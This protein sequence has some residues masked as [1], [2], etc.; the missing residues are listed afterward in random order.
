LIGIPYF[1]NNQNNLPKSLLEIRTS[2]IQGRG[3]FATRRIRKGTRII[4][5][6]G[7]LITP[8]EA[9]N[10][11]G[12][13]RAEHPL[14]LL[15]SLDK[16]TVIDAGVGGNE[17]RFI[18]H[19]CQPNCEPVIE[20]KHVFIESL[21]TITKGEELTYDYNLTRE[22]QDDDELEKRFSCNCGAK[23]CRGT[24]LKPRRTRR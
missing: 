19:S 1:S 11:Y 20:K 24:M 17:S 18:N 2:H 7:E 12:D 9:D 14:V 4:E 15:F 23:T 8:V 21:R 10:R 5:Y 16:R 6:L 22:G 3:A 13:S